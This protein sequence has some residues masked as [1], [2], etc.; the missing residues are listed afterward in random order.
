MVEASKVEKILGVQM[1]TSGNPGQLETA[2]RLGG[3]LSRQQVCAKKLTNDIIFIYFRQ[4]LA[5]CEYQLKKGGGTW[6]YP[7]LKD[8][9]EVVVELR[10]LSLLSLRRL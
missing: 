3:Q 9:R 7:S 1:V 10:I 8:V 4:K 5:Q 2:D 6:R